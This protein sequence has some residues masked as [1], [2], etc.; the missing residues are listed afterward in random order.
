MIPLNIVHPGTPNN[1]FLME[2]NGEFQQ[3]SMVKIWNHPS[4]TTI[5]K[6]MIQVPGIHDIFEKIYSNQL[7]K[8]QY[9]YACIY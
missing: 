1:H 7:Y 9:Q 5:L 3:F 8:I 4:E 2:G 6:W